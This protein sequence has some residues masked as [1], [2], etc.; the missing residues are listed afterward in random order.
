[1]S[2]H[3]FISHSSHDSYYVERIP[4][5]L[6]ARGILCWM[7]PRDIP[8]GADWAESMMGAPAEARAMGDSTSQPPDDAAGPDGRRSG[9]Q[10]PHPPGGG[11]GGREDGPGRGRSTDGR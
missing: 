2:R 11:A 6:E 8:P 1:M 9:H 10:P 7:A 4:R 3:V 5:H